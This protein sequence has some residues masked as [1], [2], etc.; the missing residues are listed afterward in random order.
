MSTAQSPSPSQ[1]PLS[2]DA[3][4]QP[5]RGKFNFWRWFWLGALVV[6]LAWAFYDFYV[7]A[8][9]V[10]WAK[11]YAAAQQ[12][13]AQSGKPVILFFTGKWCVPCRIMKRQVWADKDVEAVV[14]A[15]FTPVM[16]DVDD[17]NAAATVGH[18]GIRA[19]P[20]III[21]DA[22][23]YVLQRVDKGLGKAEFLELLS[24]VNPLNK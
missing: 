1:P 13:A 23:E 11:D 16:I 8:N 6:G 18:Y 7:P 21:T 2:T 12:L 17:P 3:A 9:H 10:V 5:P 15:R 20:V 4:P 14:A 19:T 24:K 22:H